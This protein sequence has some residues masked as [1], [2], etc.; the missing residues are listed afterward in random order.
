MAKS[1]RVRIVDTDRLIK[2]YRGDK[3]KQKVI[4]PI[5]DHLAISF[6][7]AIELMAGAKTIKKQYKVAKTLKAYELIEASP[8]ISKTALVLSRRYGMLHT[9]GVADMLIAAT[10]IVSDLPLY[11]DNIQDYNFIDGLVLYKP[12]Q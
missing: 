11:T 7:M 2:I 1:T 8:M 9:I 10:A 3:E 4:A 6:I 12:A 5:Q